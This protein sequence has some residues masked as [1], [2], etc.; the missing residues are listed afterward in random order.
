AF[1]ASMNRS[2]TSRFVSSAMSPRSSAQAVVVRIEGHLPLSTRTGHH[3][4]VV[5]LVAGRRGY[6]VEAARHEHEIAVARG[7]TLVERA[8]CG[9]HALQREATLRVAH[10]VVVG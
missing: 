3:V 9:V 4:Q 5:D 10:P 1:I 6:G 2:M 8:V 7:D